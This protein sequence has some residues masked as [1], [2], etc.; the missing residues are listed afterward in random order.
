VKLHI[1]Y[2]VAWLLALLSL[3]WIPAPP[4]LRAADSEDELKAAT[5]WLFVQY[6]HLSPGPDGVVTVGVVGR[7]SFVQ[8]LRHT[9]AGK[10]LGI[11]QV[12]VVEPKADLRQCQAI[13]VATEKN[14]E[15]RRLLESSQGLHILMIGESDRF[16]EYGGAVSLFIAD[17]HIAFETSLEALE[18]TG[19]SISSSLLKF[20]QIRSRGKGSGA[21]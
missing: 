9:L 16:L 5:V 8:A 17:G 6:S 18:R 12:R 19:L 14:E 20:G 21:K 11:H 1:R 4:V 15:V 2:H 10:S 3:L 13:Y 7:S